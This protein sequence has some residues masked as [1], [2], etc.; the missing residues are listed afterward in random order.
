MWLLT[1]S[2]RLKLPGAAPPLKRTMNCLMDKLLPLVLRGSIA[3]RIRDEDIDPQCE[4][5]P[6]DDLGGMDAARKAL[7]LA[8][9]LG[10]RLNLDNMKIESLYPEEM[11]P[12]VMPLEDFL[13]NGLPLLDKKIEDRTKQA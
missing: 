11:G 9:L 12:D 4:R 6:R 7:I 2:R 5:D 1:M 13:V 10:R 3:Q 8:R